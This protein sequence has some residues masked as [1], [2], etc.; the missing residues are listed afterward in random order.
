MV[1][2]GKK[3]GGRTTSPDKVPITAAP[4]LR[5][6]PPPRSQ[7]HVKLPAASLRVERIPTTQQPPVPRAAQREANDSPVP[8][9]VMIPPA[10]EEDTCTHDDAT[11]TASNRCTQP[12]LEVPT[13]QQTRSMHQPRRSPRHV[14]ATTTIHDPTLAPEYALHGNAFNPDTGKLAEYHE[15][16]HSS[17]GAL[18][19]ASNAMEIHQLAQGHGKITGTNTMFFIPVLA[20]PHNKKATYLCIVC[21]HRPEK[22]VP[23]HVWWTVGSD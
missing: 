22:E 2:H 3:K 9:E 7:H 21:A 10:K 6:G 4:T 14:A 15:L 18:W 1:L 5:V 16:S 11:M 19:Q 8:H 20:I 12:R 13:Q 17:D 23:H